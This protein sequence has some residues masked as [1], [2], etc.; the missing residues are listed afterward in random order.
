MSDGCYQLA[1]RNCSIFSLVHLIMHQHP[2]CPFCNTIQYLKCTENMKSA[3]N[4]DREI[5]YVVKNKCLQNFCLAAGG[6][7]FSTNE[8]HDIYLCCNEVTWCLVYV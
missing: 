4:K 7:T 2:F 5:L 1:N 3:G 6:E 8:A